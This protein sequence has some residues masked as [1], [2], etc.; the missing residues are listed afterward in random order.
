MEGVEGGMG[1]GGEEG[2]GGAGGGM[3]KERQV[4]HPHKQGGSG[5]REEER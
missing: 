2:G 1:E 3:T 4:F 5:R